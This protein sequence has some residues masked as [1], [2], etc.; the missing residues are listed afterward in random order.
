[1]DE[2]QAK[3]PN[4]THWYIMELWKFALTWKLTCPVQQKITQKEQK[5]PPKKK[6]YP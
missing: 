5:K 3:N 4:T 6:E 2:G 1:M